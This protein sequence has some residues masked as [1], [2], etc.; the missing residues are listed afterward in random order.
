M[1]GK[2][3]DLLGIK[4]LSADEINTILERAS[5][6]KNMI[7]AKSAKVINLKGRCLA[8][9]FY[10]NSTRTRLSFEMAGKI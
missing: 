10:E 1:F 5:I 8:T 7:T 6:I 3:K 4:Q 2:H 9:V